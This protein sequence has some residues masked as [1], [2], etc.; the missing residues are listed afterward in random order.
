MNKNEIKIKKLFQR[1]FNCQIPCSFWF[2]W[3]QFSDKCSLNTSIEMKRGRHFVPFCWRQSTKYGPTVFSHGFVVVLWNDE[4]LFCFASMIFFSSF[5]FFFRFV[6]FWSMFTFKDCKGVGLFVFIALISLCAKIWKNVLSSAQAL[7]EVT[8]ISMFRAESRPTYKKIWNW[9][10][11]RHGTVKNCERKNRQDF[12]SSLGIVEA[13]VIAMLESFVS[14][15]RQHHFEINTGAEEKRERK[16]RSIKAQTECCA[17][18]SRMCVCF[19]RIHK[20]IVC[21][22]WMAGDERRRK[23]KTQKEL[24]KS[25]RKMTF[26]DDQIDDENHIENVLIESTDN[27]VFIHHHYFDMKSMKLKKI[28][29]RIGKLQSNEILVSTFELRSIRMQIRFGHFQSQFATVQNC[30]T[31]AQRRWYACQWI[32]LNFHQSID[33]QRAKWTL[34]TRAE[35]MWTKRERKLEHQLHSYN[36]FIYL[37]TV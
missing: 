7:H 12:Q 16:K 30:C 21:L 1:K 37:K 4:A 2:L 28:H 29:A 22:M 36:M 3:K 26:T 32:K 35:S 27:N 25:N 17:C 33:F 20:S 5:T 19:S 24:I 10:G 14:L 23:R 31:W 9:R 18:V 13:E 34:R 8:I 15:R 6:H 11:K